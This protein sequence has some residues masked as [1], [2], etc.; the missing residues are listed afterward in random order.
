MELIDEIHKKYGKTTTQSSIDLE[1][2][3]HRNID[4]IILVD[5]GQIIADMSPG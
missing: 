5:D 1:D 3:L 4:R 2:V